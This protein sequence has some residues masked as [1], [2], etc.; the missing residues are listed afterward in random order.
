MRCLHCGSKSH[1]QILYSD[2]DDLSDSSDPLLSP[3]DN[4]VMGEVCDRIASLIKVLDDP[5][6][7]HTLDDYSVMN[8]QY[9]ALQALYQLSEHGL[10]DRVFDLDPRGILRHQSLVILRNILGWYYPEAKWGSPG[11]MDLAG[12]ISHTS[13]PVTDLGASF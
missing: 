4:V 8:F 13:D 10:M 3:D 11:L 5:N 6:Q 9:D 1:V 12:P 7:H 2:P